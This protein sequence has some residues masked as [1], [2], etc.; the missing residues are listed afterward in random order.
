VP[1]PEKQAPG[2]RQGLAPLTARVQDN[3]A[4]VALTNQL[5]HR[6]WAILTSGEHSRPPA[7]P[8]ALV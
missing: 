3:R 8:S 7:L 2:R 5:A 1:F 6:A 4:A